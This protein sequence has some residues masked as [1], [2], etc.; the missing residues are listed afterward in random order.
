VRALLLEMGFIN[1]AHCQVMCFFNRNIFIRENVRTIATKY[2]MRPVEK[3][4]IKMLNGFAEP[5]RLL[6]ATRFP[7]TSFIGLII[8]V[9]F[10]KRLFV[11]CRETIESER[12]RVLFSKSIAFQATS[13][14]Q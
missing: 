7:I 6:C 9:N 13:H 2:Q 11:K 14:Q 4:P 8:S 1:F 12:R 3:E 5:K 10:T